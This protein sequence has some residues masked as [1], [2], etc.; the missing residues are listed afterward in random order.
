MEQLYIN[1]LHIFD[2]KCKNLDFNEVCQN[3]VNVRHIFNFV[4]DKIK[5][6]VYKFCIQTFCI[7]NDLPQELVTRLVPT[8]KYLKEI[9]NETFYFCKNSK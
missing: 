6:I 7:Q 3:C 5:N 2:C 4:A 8:E 1:T 9:K